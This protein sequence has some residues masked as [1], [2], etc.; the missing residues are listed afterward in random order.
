MSR[1]TLPRSRPLALHETSMRRLAFSCWIT[2]GVGAIRSSATSPSGTLP[3]SGAS[4]RIL[5]RFDR[6]V[7]HFSSTPDRDIEDLLIFVDLTRLCAADKRHGCTTDIA[8]SQAESLRRFR[9]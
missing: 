3:P 9:L 1:A 4:I 8:G 6:S 2:F 7:R 5:V